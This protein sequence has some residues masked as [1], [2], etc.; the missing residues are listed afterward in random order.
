MIRICLVQRTCKRFAL[1][2]DIVNVH[3][4]RVVKGSQTVAIDMQARTL[5]VQHGEVTL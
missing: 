1:L 4:R 3:M 2:N 5:S